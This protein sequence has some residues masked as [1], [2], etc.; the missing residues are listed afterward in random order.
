MT[1]NV[2]KNA[3]LYKAVTKSTFK[4]SKGRKFEFDSMTTPDDSLSIRQLLINHTRGLGNV[5]TRNGIYTEDE[6]APRYVDL[7]DRKN[8]VDELRHRIDLAKAEIEKEK[9]AAEEAKSTI[10]SPRGSG[11][12]PST[13]EEAPQGA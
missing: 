3:P 9:K 8:A 6:V 12:S 13:T 11:G 1:K 10:L 2:N 7:N 4:P 5:P